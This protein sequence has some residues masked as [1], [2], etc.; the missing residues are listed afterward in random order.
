MNC[1]E[2]LISNSLAL[3]NTVQCEESY[4]EIQRILSMKKYSDFLLIEIR[5]SR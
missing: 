5:T 3:A 4:C 1:G 2:N